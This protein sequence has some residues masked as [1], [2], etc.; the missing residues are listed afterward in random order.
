MAKMHFNKPKG[1]PSIKRDMVPSRKMAMKI[2][3]IL[4]MSLILN[5]YFILQYVIQYKFN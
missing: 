5:A 4:A 2:G 1:S 3:F